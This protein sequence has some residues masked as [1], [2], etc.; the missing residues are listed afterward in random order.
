MIGVA[1]QTTFQHATTSRSTY[2][3]MLLIAAV[4]YSLIAV[5]TIAATTQQPQIGELYRGGYFCNQGYSDASILVRSNAA[6]STVWNV[7]FNFSVPNSS[8]YCTGSYTGS[9]TFLSTSGVYQFQGSSW[10]SNPCG[11]IFVPTFTFS[12]VQGTSSIAPPVWYTDVISASGNCAQFKVGKSTLRRPCSAVKQGS[13]VQLT[14][15][16]ETES[17]SADATT[18]T[19]SWTSSPSSLVSSITQSST[20]TTSMSQDVTAPSHTLMTRTKTGSIAHSTSEQNSVTVS[21]SHP[22]MTVVTTHSYSVSVLKNST[23]LSLSVSPS[24]TRTSSA[25]ITQPSITISITSPTPTWTRSHSPS[26]QHTSATATPLLDMGVAN[27]DPMIEVVRNVAGSVS[28]VAAV[29][30]PVDLSNVN[31]IVMISHVDCATSPGNRHR[32]VNSMRDGS[33]SSYMISP[34]MDF[35]WVAVAWGNL[36]LSVVGGFGVNAIVATLGASAQRIA[37]RRRGG[38]PSAY[39]TTITTSIL[40]IA[41]HLDVQD[42]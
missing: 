20:S 36:A 33:L 23:T 31:T 28:V 9:I 7:M 2:E 40:A 39:G 27:K 15:V 32:G 8:P 6:S 5:T 35:G 24:P 22:T 16:T 17:F 42:I 10:I 18:M 29:L 3:V 30:S 12:I 41:F 14:C 13:N 25:T 26:L 21:H 38:H 19:T 4:T 34:F 1:Q 37:R 11:Y